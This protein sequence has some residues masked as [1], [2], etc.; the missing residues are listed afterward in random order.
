LAIFFI[1]IGIII[2]YRLFDIQV[3]HGAAY[4]EESQQNIVKSEATP[5]P[6]GMIIDR[7]GI[8]IA[9]NDQ[10][11]CVYM[12]NAGL[13]PADLNNVALQFTD[14][15]EKNKDR[16]NMTLS[17][18]LTIDPFT[19]GSQSLDDA[20]KWQ[21]DKNALNLAKSDI[22]V[23]PGALFDRL[24]KKFNIDGA[25]SDEDAYKIMTVRYEILINQWIF[26]TGTPIQIA[27][28]ISDV[29]LAQIEE[30]HFELPGL[31]A[32]VIPVRKY[33]DASLVS[34]VIGI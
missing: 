2:I 16:Y 19:F 15:L 33:I 21:G 6:R 25:Y 30:R 22:E 26:D 7:N 3:I 13:K 32:S 9:V 20:M 18:Y 8:P 23:D 5:A 4:L 17:K 11:Y 12:E 10:N 24:R 34:H 27:Q 14:I 29:S 28:N 1:F 31:T